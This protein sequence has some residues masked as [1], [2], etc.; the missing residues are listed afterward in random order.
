MTLNGHFALKAVTGSATDE[1]AFLAFWQNCSKICRA[2]HIPQSPTYYQW[3][4][5]CPWILV[6]SKVRFIGIFTGVRWRGG[7]KWEW[8]CRKLRF[9]FLSLNIFS[10]PSHWRPQLHHVSKNCAELFLSEL[11]KISTNCENFW[12]SDGK[13]EKLIHS[14]IHLLLRWSSTIQKYSNQSK[15]YSP[16]SLYC[17]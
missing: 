11:C 2:T 6:S 9:S 14:F 12:H 5:F 15:Y 16:L 10:E 1:L 7:G 13:E 17:T 4:K 8:G 3:Q